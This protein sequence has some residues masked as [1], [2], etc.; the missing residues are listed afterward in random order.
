MTQ[1]LRAT[2]HITEQDDAI[3]VAVIWSGVELDRP[4]TGGFR[5]MKGQMKLAQRLKRAIDDQQAYE[6]PE[7][8]HDMNGQSYVEVRSLVLGK[9]MDA[10]LKRLGY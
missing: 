5:L 7:V 6:D 10:D 4:F 9:Y 1:Q 8:V 3:Y 2:A